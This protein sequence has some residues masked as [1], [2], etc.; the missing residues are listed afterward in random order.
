MLMNV[1]P[2]DEFL[3]ST[4]SFFSIPIVLPL[5]LFPN[6]LPIHIGNSNVCIER[7]VLKLASFMLPNCRILNLWKGG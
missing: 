3:W 4:N 7:N 1:G 2:I 5:H 6:C